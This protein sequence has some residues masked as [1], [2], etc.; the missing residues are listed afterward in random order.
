[1]A[2]RKRAFHSEQ[3]RERIQASQL[4]NRLRDNALAEKELMTASQVQSARILLNKSLPDLQSIQHSGDADRPIIQEIRQ[5]VVETR[6][7]DSEEVSAA[8]ATGEV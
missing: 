6:H 2:A 5:V 4:I 8:T 7:S 1:M 3:V